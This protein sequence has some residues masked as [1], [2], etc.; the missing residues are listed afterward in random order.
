MSFLKPF[1]LRQMLKTSNHSFRTVKEWKKRENDIEQISTRTSH[2]L[3]SS[4]DLLSFPAKNVLLGVTDS[5]S[6]ISVVEV[7]H[8]AGSSGPGWNF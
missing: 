5:P 6:H 3:S 1:D 2:T 8:Q 4:I 7:K